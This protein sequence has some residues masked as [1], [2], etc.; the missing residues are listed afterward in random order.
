MTQIRSA[1]CLTTLLLTACAN[2]PIE[3]KPAAM[4]KE[5]EEFYAAQRY[6][7][8]IAQY[9]KVRDAYA[10][11]ELSSNAELRIA[12]SYFDSERFIEA[13]A[14]YDE[15]RKLHPTHPKTPYALFRMGLANYN[16]IT[17]IDR[18]QTPQKNAETYFEE[19][20]TQY[21][22]SE[23][24][25]EVANKLADVKEMQL[26]YEQYVARFYI[27]AEKY[28]A[29]VSRLEAALK[30]Y[31]NNQLHDETWFLLGTSLLRSGNHEKAREAFNKLST[32]FPG[33]KYI[34]EASKLLESIY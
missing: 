9:K 8:A 16:Q 17:T 1:L 10:S 2:V 25:A 32:N 18:D 26:Q 11:T 27:R 30:K 14:A 24:A 4:Y 22:K 23:Y 34:L 28:G 31:P 12:D 3:T 19:F 13:T 15:F 7:D 6:D 33:S 29:A 21:P 20:L 5:G